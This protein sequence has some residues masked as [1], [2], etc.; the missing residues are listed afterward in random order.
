MGKMI[1]IRSSWKAY[2]DL[3]HIELEF[4]SDEEVD[5]KIHFF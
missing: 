2:V 4:R 5:A 1:L 3:R